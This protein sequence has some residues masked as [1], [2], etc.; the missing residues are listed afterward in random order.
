MGH[1]S[2]LWLLVTRVDVSSFGEGSNHSSALQL[3]CRI[4]R[5]TL[6]CTI[7]TLIAS[8]FVPLDTVYTL[9]VDTYTAI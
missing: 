4:E 7:L 6:L 1:F 2:A 8:V 9:Y 5:Q 3:D